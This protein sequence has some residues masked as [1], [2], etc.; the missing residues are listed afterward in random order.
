[1]ETSAQNVHDNLNGIVDYQTHHRLR[2]AQVGLATLLSCCLKALSG[3]QL[4][5]AFRHFDPWLF[6]CLQ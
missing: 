1:M 4:A 2:E 6:K 5:A 3:E